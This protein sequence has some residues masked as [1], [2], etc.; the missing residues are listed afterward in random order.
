MEV[1]RGVSERERLGE[2]GGLN[3]SS[4]WER[5]E[6]WT[7]QEVGKEA[8]RKMDGTV[9]QERSQPQQQLCRNKKEKK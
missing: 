3:S 9:A 2:E 6:R 7:G 4:S 8:G 1:A 5:K